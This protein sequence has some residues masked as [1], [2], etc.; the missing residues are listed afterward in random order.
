MGGDVIRVHRELDSFDLARMTEE[1]K[2][3]YH[4]LESALEITQATNSQKLTRQVPMFLSVEEND[5]L[6]QFALESIR[7]GLRNAGFNLVAAAEESAVT[8]LLSRSEITHKSVRFSGSQINTAEVTLSMSG[9][10]TFAGKGISVPSASGDAV[11]SDHAS[12]EREAV[13]EAADG[14][15]DELKALTDA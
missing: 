11:G 6:T 5:A 15:I 14:L 1:D 2:A 13:K 8:L 9:K 10:W 4:R 7:Q 12:L 3:V